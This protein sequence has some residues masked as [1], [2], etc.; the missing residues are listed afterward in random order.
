MTGDMSP[1]KFLLLWFAMLAI[2]AGVATVRG[3][4]RRQR[5]EFVF[6]PVPPPDARFSDTWISGGTGLFTA[7]RNCL[8]VIRRWARSA[9]R[10]RGC[11]RATRIASATAPSPSITTAA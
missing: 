3:L 9:C 5:G 1:E 7:A 6:R 2:L 8:C 4:L 11:A 10:A